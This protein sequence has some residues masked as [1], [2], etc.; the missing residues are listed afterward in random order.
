MTGEQA[1]RLPSDSQGARGGADRHR[2]RWQRMGKLDAFANRNVSFPS[3]AVKCKGFSPR[4]VSSVG[5]RESP[6]FGKG[7]F[8]NYV[9]VA[10]IS[11]ATVAIGHHFKFTSLHTVQK[12]SI[13]GQGSLRSDYKPEGPLEDF[14]F[15]F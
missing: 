7:T 9:A 13:R 11:G 6:H 10:I 5:K 4:L 14:Y 2:H 8:T 15:E 1:G 3:T 12:Y